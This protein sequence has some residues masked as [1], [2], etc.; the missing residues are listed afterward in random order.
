MSQNIIDR[1]L[2]EGFCP[3]HE[4]PPETHFFNFFRAYVVFCNVSHP[5][6]WPNQLMD[7]HACE[8][9]AVDAP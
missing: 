1:I 5:V 4:W 9:T 8:Y 2:P 3:L 7:L 6:F